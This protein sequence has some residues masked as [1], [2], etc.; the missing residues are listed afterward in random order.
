MY[1]VCFM[2]GPWVE[3]KRAYASARHAG[4]RREEKASVPGAARRAHRED[5]GQ[6]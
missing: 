1:K 3:L 6:Y 4:G 2:M 5:T